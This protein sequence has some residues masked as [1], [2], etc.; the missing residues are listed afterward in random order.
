MMHQYILDRVIPQ[1]KHPYMLRRQKD[2]PSS[3]ILVL[4]TPY[5]T[6]LCR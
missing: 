5:T 1:T 6:F 4:G 3:R 2:D